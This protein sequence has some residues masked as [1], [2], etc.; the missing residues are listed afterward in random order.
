[1]SADL[2]VAEQRGISAE[3]PGI[4]RDIRNHVANW[5]DIAARAMMASGDDARA[6]AAQRDEIGRQVRQDLEILT[7]IAADDGFGFREESEQIIAQ[8]KAWTTG[9]IVGLL[10]LCLLATV[11]LVRNIVQPLDSMARAMIRLSRGDFT[12]EAPH[13]ARRDEIGHMGQS[14]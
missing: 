10:L 3:I 14:L 9:V 8:T 2:A 7:Q 6:L 11:M 13:T 12:V 5:Q 1:F 4:A